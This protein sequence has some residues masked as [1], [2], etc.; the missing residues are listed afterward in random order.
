MSKHSVRY[1][2][3]GGEAMKLNVLWNSS[4]TNFDISC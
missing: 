3:V 1:D 4:V 2:D